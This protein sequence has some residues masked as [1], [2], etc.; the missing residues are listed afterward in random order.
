MTGGKRVLLIIGGGIAAYKSLD[1][2]RRLRE[3]GVKV[4]VVMTAAAQQFITPLAAGALTAEKVYTDLFD[5]EAEQ[6]VGHIRLARDTGLIIV[7]PATADLMAKMA[8]GLA[9]DL[10][11][12]VLLATNRPVLVAPAMNPAMWAHPA[13]QRNV[14]TL[15]TDGIAFIGPESGEMAESGEAGLGRM[16]EPLAIAERALELLEA[17]SAPQ[18]GPLSGKHVVITSGPTH[19]PIDPVRYIANRSSGKQGH[20]IAAA[21]AEAGARVTLISGP[22]TLPD[23]AGVTVIPVETAKEMLAA[24]EAALPADVAIMA[25]AVADWRVAQE[26]SEK[27]KKD[28]SGQPPALALIENPDI[29]STVGHLA[30]N[31]PKLVVGFAAETQNLIANAQGKLQRKAADWIVANDVSPATGVMGGDANTVRIVT[32]DGIEDW[33]TLGKTEVARRLVA[34]IAAALETAEG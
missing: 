33:P 22:V 15:K 26:G 18:A 32:H 29:L 17:G 31:R 10:A 14:A 16:A 34:R 2:I 3:R 1:L 8:Q 30:G 23:P 21:A 7:A 6:D 4:K 13:T 28:G 25:A 24:V 27:I 19:E 12:T 9:G 11:S 20:A 5:R